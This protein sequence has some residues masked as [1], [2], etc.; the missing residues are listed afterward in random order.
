MKALLRCFVVSTTLA[1]LSS[2]ANDCRPEVGGAVTE[3]QLALSNKEFSSSRLEEFRKR[4]QQLVRRCNVS[5]S[6]IQI[7]MMGTYDQLD[8]IVLA[9]DLD[10]ARQ[11]MSANSAEWV[12]KEPEVEG[13][14]PDSRMHRVARWGSP[15]MLKVF[16][17]FGCPVDLEDRGAG[18]PLQSSIGGVQR[19]GENSMLL[20]NFGAS[21]NAMDA[22][23]LTALD[24]AILENDIDVARALIE[25]G[26][27]VR[28]EGHE[29]A[30]TLELLRKEGT[31][32]M[33]LLLEGITK[34]QLEE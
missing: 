3:I 34:E 8:L 14:T 33:R 16:I 18:T 28:P 22:D 9:D 10:A 29:N 15:Q 32:D 2:C 12:C 21:P 24:Y 25:A 7:P 13:R 20:L 6:G 17:D 1:S 23:G 26:A 5:H 31:Q 11:Q 27:K 19:K 30:R 4:M